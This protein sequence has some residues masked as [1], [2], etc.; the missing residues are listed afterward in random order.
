MELSAYFKGN[1][2]LETDR[3]L[4]RK[5]KPSDS[6]AMY[7]YACKSETTKYLLWEPHP[8]YSYTVEL[9]RF[10]QKE[11]SEGRFFDLAIIHKEAKKMIGTV[12][13]T[14]YDA[15][16]LCAEVGY[17][18]SP[19]FW[20]KG[21]AVEALSV[22]LNFAFCELEVNRVEAKYIAENIPSLRVM[23]KC[24]MSFEGIQRKKLFIKGQFRDI[25][26]C[27]ILKNEYFTEKRV[28]IYKENESK[29]LFARLFHKN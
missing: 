10:L 20:G 13:F 1:L 25:G 7:E 17:V 4:I 12:G 11:Y 3:L 2:T 6:G 27:S 5:I 21:I 16:N 28:N 29:G 26:I 24:G 23:Q 22:L 14:T 18:I 15:K 19:D 9:T 8:Y